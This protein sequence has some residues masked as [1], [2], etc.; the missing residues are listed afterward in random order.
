VEESAASAGVK[1]NALQTSTAEPGTVEFV[2]A[3]VALE[4]TTITVPEVPVKTS[5]STEPAVGFIF[6]PSEIAPASTDII[7][8]TIER[9]Y[10]SAPTEVAS[11]MNIMKELTHQ[12]V[13][14]FFT[15]MRSYIKLVLSERSS[16]EFARML[17][18]NEIETVI[19]KAQSKVGHI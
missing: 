12:M 18:D 13:Q 6:A 3:P 8:T 7:H 10:G 17:L 2:V 19:L 4:A 1:D 11:V 9:G 15:S 16:F 14:Q 5:A